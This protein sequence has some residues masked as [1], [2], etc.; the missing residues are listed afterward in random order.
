MSTRPTLL[1]VIGTLACTALP[2]DTGFP[3]AY[4]QDDC[5]P[6]DGP[7]LTLVLS[8]H[9]IDSRMDVSYPSLR[10]TS[11][12]PPSSLS[13]ASFSWA[14]DTQSDGY[15][16]LCDS[17]ES[18]VAATR[19][20]VS[21]DRDQGSGEVATGSV[22]VELEDGGVIAGPFAARRLGNPVLCG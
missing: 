2:T 4:L 18:C 11:W 15:A 20:S 21:F 6:W 9:E 7:A 12:R 3:L 8:Q 22:R 16:A 14:G 19:V 5:A 1:L 10:I 17:A 13:G